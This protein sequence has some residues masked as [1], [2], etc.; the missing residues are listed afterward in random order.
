[1]P[2]MTAQSVDPVR[3]LGILCGLMFIPHILA[4]FI[5]RESVFDFFRTAGFRPVG[6]FVNVAVVIET[7]SATLLILGVAL[8]YAGALA[9]SFMFCA[10]VATWRVSGG[11]W[12]W[13][14]GG[15]ELHMF[16]AACC[17]I[18]A[19]FGGSSPIFPSN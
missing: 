2:D 9:G 11:R 17:F 4:A 8:P 14:L 19:L 10:G 3:L 6:L 15:C 7:V 13:N 18:V 5:S 16:W 12:V 1:M